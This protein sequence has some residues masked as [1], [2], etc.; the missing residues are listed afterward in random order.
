MNDTDVSVKLVPG[1]IETDDEGAALV[2]RW[3]NAIRPLMRLV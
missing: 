3:N 2:G 1:A